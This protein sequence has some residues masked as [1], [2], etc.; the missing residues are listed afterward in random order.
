MLR[1]Y[2]IVNGILLGVGTGGAVTEWIAATGSASFTSG[3]PGA[4]SPN[5]TAPANVACSL[6]TMQ[7][8]FMLDAPSGSR[9]ASARRASLTSAVDVPAMRLTFM[10]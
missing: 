10:F 6:E 8:R 9:G 7:V 2:D 1:C 4:A 5:F 3:V